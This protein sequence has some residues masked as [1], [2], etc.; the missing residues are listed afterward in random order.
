[1][2]T[3]EHELGVHAFL[4]LLSTEVKQTGVIESCS[5][6]S[7]RA[8]FEPGGTTDSAR[9]RLCAVSLNGRKCISFIAAE[10]VRTWGEVKRCPC[11]E[12]QRATD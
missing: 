4:F 5:S 12:K 10:K 3:R 7:V 2:Q 11:Y 6:P 8:R 9:T 1:M